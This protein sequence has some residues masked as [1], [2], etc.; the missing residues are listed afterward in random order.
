MVVY[1]VH[2]TPVIA[3]VMKMLSPVTEIINKQ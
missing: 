3:I 2:I 1:T